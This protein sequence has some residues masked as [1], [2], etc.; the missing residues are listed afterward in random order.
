MKRR[1][2]QPC[3]LFAPPPS[4]G[5]LLLLLSLLIVLSAS[6]TYDNNPDDLS[7]VP[8]RHTLNKKQ[9]K[10]VL[11]DLPL[12]DYSAPQAAEQVLDRIGSSVSLVILF[13]CLF[14]RTYIVC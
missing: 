3:K 9:T 6:L 7:E 11:D 13:V 2:Q 10:V 1:R 8:T 14:P 5:F 4:I 12:G